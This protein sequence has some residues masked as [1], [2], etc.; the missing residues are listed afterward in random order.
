VT[1][2]PK[3][4]AETPSRVHNVKPN[5][6]FYGS[7]ASRERAKTPAECKLEYRSTKNSLQKPTD[8]IENPSSDIIALTFADGDL[9]SD[10]IARARASISPLQTHL[11]IQFCNTLFH[12][13]TMNQYPTPLFE[14]NSFL[15]AASTAYTHDTATERHFDFRVPP[16][17]QTFSADPGGYCPFGFLPSSSKSAPSSEDTPSQLRAPW[18][19][20]V[21]S[22]RE[23]HPQAPCQRDSFTTSPSYL[24][25]PSG[26]SPQTPSHRIR[27]PTLGFTPSTVE[28][29]NQAPATPHD[30]TNTPSRRTTA[31]QE[32]LGILGGE[33]EFCYDDLLKSANE[34]GESSEFESWDEFCL[35]D[36]L[37]H[38]AHLEK[39]VWD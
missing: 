24:S 32:E 5:G 12:A 27:A 10:S 3:D 29:Q 8:N 4:F 39:S 35:R 14:N 15:A 17:P 23:D 19:S 30:L 11:S 26:T 22:S 25:L 38:S 31:E 18:A 34:T 33:E 7:E 28:S 13:A 9:F 37:Q 2:T 1:S 20:D 21:Q 6:I 16:Q 36:S